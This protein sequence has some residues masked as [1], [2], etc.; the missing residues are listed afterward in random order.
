MES[1]AVPDTIID[2][3]EAMLKKNPKLRWDEAVA[4]I[5]KAR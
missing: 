2:Q 4:Q 1:I 5:V 3:V